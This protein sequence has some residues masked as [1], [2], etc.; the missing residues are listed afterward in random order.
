MAPLKPGPSVLAQNLPQ[1]VLILPS[2][3]SKPASL[4][5]VDTIMS[6]PFQTA[7]TLRR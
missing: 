2:H 3:S 7:A 1:A 6:L 5:C 4:S